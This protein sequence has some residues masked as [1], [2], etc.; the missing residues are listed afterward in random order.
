MGSIATTQYSSKAEARRILGTLLVEI[1]HVSLPPIVASTASSHVDFTAE[2]DAPYFPIPFKETETAA[3][4]K[5]IEGSVAAS[6]ADLKTDR[7][8]RRRTVSVN[9]EKT[10]AFLCQA[11]LAKVGGLGKLDPEVKALL[12][13]ETT[14]ADL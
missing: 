14:T 3:A 13:G 4:L 11:Y 12:K 2:R 5:A 9:L 1:D 10:T 8:G 6:L 7:Q